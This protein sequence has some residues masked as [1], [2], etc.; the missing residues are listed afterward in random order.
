MHDRAKIFI[1]DDEEAVRDALVMLLETAGYEV[2]TFR[3]A[4]EFLTSYTP[5]NCECLI[6]DVS[7]PE[8]DGPALQAE[9]ILRGAMLPIIFLSGYGTIPLTVRAMK[10]GAENFLTKPVEGTSLLMQVSMALEKHTLRKASSDCQPANLRLAKL[11]DREREVLKLA[12]A[13]HANKE[14]GRRLG[15]SHRTAEVHRA[16]ILQKTGASNL[17]ELASFAGMF[18]NIQSP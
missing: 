4:K 14:I 9:L 8:M 12:L 17:L 2:S 10:A 11:S 6:L 15:I 1:V 5:G 3:S 13:G 16:R 7:M 18:E